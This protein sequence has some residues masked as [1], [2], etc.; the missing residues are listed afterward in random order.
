M[1]IHSQQVISKDPSA[2]DKSSTFSLVLNDKTMLSHLTI[3]SITKQPQPVHETKHNTLIHVSSQTNLES[4]D[5]SMIENSESHILNN[6]IEEGS[7]DATQDRFGV[8]I[9]KTTNPQFATAHQVPTAK[10]SSRLLQ[11]A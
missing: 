11:E 5:N 7:F 9:F 4:K 3:Q 10:D 8:T 2:A 1:H 6:V